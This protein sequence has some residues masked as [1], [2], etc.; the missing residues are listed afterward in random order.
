MNIFGII[1]TLA[2]RIFYQLGLAT[3]KEKTE[4]T[5]VKRPGSVHAAR[6]LIKG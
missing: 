3:V 1:K 4:G 2:R 6:P 5:N